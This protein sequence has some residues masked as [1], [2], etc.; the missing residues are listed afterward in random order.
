MP[1]PSAV[2][3]A[4]ISS[5]P[6]IVSERAFSALKIFPLSGR[7]AWYLR[8][9]PCFSEPPADSPSTTNSSQRTGSRSLQS[10]SLPGMP[11]QTLAQL[12]RR[13]MFVEPFAQLFIHQLLDVAFDVAVQLAFGL[14]FKLRL[15]QPHAYYGDQ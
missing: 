9:R 6:S 1:V 2:M 7:I 15:R 3:M 13:R 4:R 8:S 12:R 11:L 5:W 14:P 10:A